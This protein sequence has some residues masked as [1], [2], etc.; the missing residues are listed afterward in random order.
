[1]KYCSLHTDV[2][3]K[4]FYSICKLHV[5]KYFMDRLKICKNIDTREVTKDY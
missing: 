1:M 3:V 2:L 4:K 5:G